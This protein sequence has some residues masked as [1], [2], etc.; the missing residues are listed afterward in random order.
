MFFDI[1]VIS[2]FVFV[3]L[4]LVGFGYSRWIRPLQ[5]GIPPG[6]MILLLVANITLFGGFIGAFSWWFGVPGSFA[7]SLPPL[8]GRM[9]GAAGWTFAFISLAALLHPS[10]R[11]VR[12]YLWMLMVY[13][14]PLTVA[15]LLFH[16]DRFDFGKPI[17]YTFF[18]VVV[19]LDVVSITFL[20]RQPKILPDSDLDLAPASGLQKGWLGLVALVTGL[21]G[22]ALLL[23]HQGPIPQVWAWQ[24]DALSSRLIAAMLLTI[25][26][27]AVYA[28]PRAETARLMLGATAIYGLGLALASLYNLLAGKPV[29][30]A[31]LVV[32][33]LMSLGSIMLLA[34]RTRTAQA[35]A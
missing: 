32:F 11:R 12:W 10:R 35:P 6:G 17:T 31:Y 8:A 16:L 4:G 33:G 28:L 1:A 34:I 7:W 15:V 25:F 5:P 18:L 3:L 9:L 20:L 27:G 19:T 21:W 30:P 13:M 22:L 29:N 26:T 24:T 14:V 2:F 23:T